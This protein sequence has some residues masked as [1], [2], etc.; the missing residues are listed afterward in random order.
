MFQ[1]DDFIG[2]GNQ[3]GVDDDAGGVDDPQ[4]RGAPRLYCAGDAYRAG[5][6]IGIDLFRHSV[7]SNGR[8]YQYENEKEIGWNTLP[9]LL[10]RGVGGEVSRKIT[11]I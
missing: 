4:R 2:A 5:K 6:R 11:T 3:L 7:F 1:D 10:W 9:P 8:I